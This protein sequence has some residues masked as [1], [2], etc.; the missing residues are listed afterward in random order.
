MILETLL[1][2]KSIVVVGG[3]ENTGKPGGKIIKNIISSGY[4]GKIIA[5]NPKYEKIQGIKSYKNIQDIP[6]CDLA[7][8]SIPAKLCPSAVK[9][10]TTDKNIKS[11]IIISAGFSEK[12]EEGKKLEEE[13]VSY[14]EEAEGCLIGPNCTGII[15]PVYAGIFTSPVPKLKPQSCDLISGSGATAAF[16]MESAMLKG[17]SFSNVFTV[18]NSAQTGVEDI[19]EYMDL[20]Y[21]SKTCAPIKLL[22]V[23]KI[24]NP[25]L[26]LHHASSLIRKGCKIAAIK[27]GSTDAGTRAAMSHTGAIAG[28]DMAVDAL[29]RKAG[30]VRCFGREELTNVA[31]VFSSKKL[32]GKNIAIITH[33][34]GPGVMLAD[35]LSAGGLEIPEIAGDKAD[36]LLKLLEPGASVSNPVDLLATGNAKQL[37]LVIDYCDK[38]FE[39]IDGIVV[40]FGTTGL[41]EVFDTYEVL[42]EKMET[43]DIPVFPVLP[44]VI[45]AKD[46]VEYFLSLGHICFPDEVQ[47]GSAITRIFNTP[48][49]ADE[50]IDLWGIDVPKIRRIIEKSPEGY[51]E[52]KTIDE[53]FDAAMIPRVPEKTV[54]VEEELS[55]VAKELGFPLVLKVIGPVHKSDVGGVVLNIKNEDHLFS[56]FNRLLRIKDAKG[57]LVQPMISG[58]ELYIGAKYEQDYGHVILCGLGGIFVEV[59]KDISSGLAPLTINEALSMVRSLKS[60][61]II[62][63]FRGNEGIDE[64][65]FANTITHLSTLLRFATEIKELD[66]NPLIGKGRQL[67]TVDARAYL[68]KES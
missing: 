55:E 63:G 17:L 15:T 52:P 12:D 36:E 44:S 45:T 4:K 5:V 22:Y 32:K 53:L 30:I 48:S 67:F 11:F 25:D 35:A 65:E 14:I 6:L 68:R 66:I 33:A 19:L 43:S 47:L 39:N 58:T 64:Y 41:K 40:I 46:E 20:H 24:E 31:C 61:K 7:I 26:F 37:R 16:I 10:L 8:L 38:Y 1:S 34:G 29:F 21:D 13:I 56:E 42:H 3:S 50:K 18:G 57:V 28:S 51:L 23:E 60:Y 54:S 9:T 49:P 2:P 27:A 59:L 62:R